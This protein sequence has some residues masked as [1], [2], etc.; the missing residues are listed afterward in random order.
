MNGVVKP[1]PLPVRI[2]LVLINLIPS[3]FGCFR[4][5]GTTAMVAG[6]APDLNTGED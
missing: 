5:I 4:I 2:I 1:F 6:F 3:V